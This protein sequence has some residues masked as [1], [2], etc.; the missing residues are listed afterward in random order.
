MLASLI[1]STCALLRR[2]GV[3]VAD[4]EVAM[5]LITIR[6]DQLG[7]GYGHSTAQ[8]DAATALFGAGS[9]GL[10]ATYTAKAA[11]ALLT[12][13][14]DDAR[15]LFWHTLSAALPRHLL[16]DVSVDILPPQFAAYLAR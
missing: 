7:A 1:R 3:E 11:A 12:T 15:P 6:H 2:E 14:A 4:A 10:D 5:R 16:R 8:G 9:V 13:T